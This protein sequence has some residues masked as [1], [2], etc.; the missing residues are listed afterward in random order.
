MDCKTRVHAHPTLGVFTEYPDMS[1]IDSAIHQGVY[2][3]TNHRTVLR[4]HGAE[5]MFDQH[6]CL[7][8]EGP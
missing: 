3:Y 8:H 2:Q 6:V 5:H 1:D 4:P 7:V